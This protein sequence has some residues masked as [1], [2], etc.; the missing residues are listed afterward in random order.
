[1]LVCA[2]HFIKCQKYESNRN[3]ELVNRELNMKL[4]NHSSPGYRYT[5]ITECAFCIAMIL[6]VSFCVWKQGCAIIRK[7]GVCVF[8][9]VVQKIMIFFP[10]IK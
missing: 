9:D 6:F 10:T 8:F 1:M 5:P 4:V 2:L 3:P 7:D